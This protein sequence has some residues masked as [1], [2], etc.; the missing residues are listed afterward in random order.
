MCKWTALKNTV[1]FPN[2]SN[3]L[4]NFWGFLNLL[5]F[6]LNKLKKLYLFCTKNV[7]KLQASEE[8]VFL[9]FICAVALLGAIV[10]N[11][12]QIDHCINGI[13]K[14]I[15]CTLSNNCR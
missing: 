9:S 8:G 2:I 10:S 1:L 12:L 14:G 7:D 4:V 11:D 15:E 3:F 6:K 13:D 5:K